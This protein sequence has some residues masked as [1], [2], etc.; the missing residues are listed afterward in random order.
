[1]FVASVDAGA[2][3]LLR[4][5]RDIEGVQLH[6]QRHALT[7]ISAAVVI[8]IVI[9]A[10][11]VGGY[12]YTTTMM[13]PGTTTTSSANIN[14]IVPAA[15][16]EGSVTVYTSITTAAIQAIITAFNAQY[17]SIKV[18]YYSG[19]ANAV[20]SKVQTE[21]SGGINAVDVVGGITYLTVATLNSSSLLASYV[22]P[23]IAN[24]SASDRIGS[25]C[26][27]TV[28]YTVG[29]LYNT[30]LVNASSLPS[31][32]TA[33]AQDTALTGKI[34][35]GDP[36]THFTTGQWLL[37]LQPIMGNSSWVSF[38]QNLASLKPR[39]Y[40]SMTPG[41]GGVAAGDVSVGIGLASDAATL[42]KQGGPISVKFL[43]PL[44]K[45]DSYAC[46]AVKAPHPNAARLFLNFMLSQKGESAEASVGDQMIRSDVPQSFASQLA[47]ATVNVFGQQTLAQVQQAQQGIFKQTFA[48]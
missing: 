27:G 22:P 8:V 7:R 35:M 11:G 1:V 34:G 41:A 15:N 36:V 48:G 16:Q 44:Q 5:S 17:P 39:F 26:Y 25:Y 12:Y 29:L 3:R 24:V 31:T 43:Q 2:R 30:K 47:G 21:A 23:E 19:S 14:S 33:L 9:A 38:L 20:T 46:I 32:W 18:N 13:S 40:P 42:A 4:L 10:A 6:S 28:Q 37:S 45:F